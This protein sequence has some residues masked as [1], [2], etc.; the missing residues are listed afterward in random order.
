MWPEIEI[1]KKLSIVIPVYNEERRL[2]K[3][4]TALKGLS[5]PRGLKLKEIIF[6]N[7]GS[8][9]RSI[10]ILRE[11]IAQNKELPIEIIS[12]KINRG[13]GYAVKKGMLKSDSDY[14]LLCD[15]D[16][17]TPLS[18]LKKFITHI[19]KGIDLIIG[20][21][22]NGKSTVIIHQPK[23][24][25]I[26]GKGFTYLTR[27]MLDLP[28]T[29]FTCGFKLFSRRSIDVIFGNSKINRW[30][31]DAEIIYIGTQNKLSLKECPVLWSDEK[32]SHV[33]VVTAIPNTIIEIFKILYFH[34]ISS[35]YKTII[36]TPY[37]QLSKF[38]S[39][40]SPNK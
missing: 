3:T 17:S 14:T 2:I 34:G 39:L 21:R 37:I 19:N 5:L 20:T 29:D 8:N 26:L 35:R 24:R 28:I 9:D 25:E 6:V 33:N 22:K 11:F 15:A 38:G 40:F 7:D 27:F 10:E 23:A 18:E 36:S 12:Y 13:K 31:Y 16:I 30:G 4:F 32:N 1:M